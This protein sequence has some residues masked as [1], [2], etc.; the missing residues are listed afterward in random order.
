VFKR[1]FT[2]HGIV[3]DAMG[4]LHVTDQG[5]GRVLKLPPKGE[6]GTFILAASR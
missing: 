6:V 1:F 3:V 5:K 4:N 2:P